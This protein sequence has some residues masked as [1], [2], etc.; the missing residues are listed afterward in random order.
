MPSVAVV[1]GASS[2]IG[3]ATTRA[4]AAAGWNVIATARRPETAESLREIADELSGVELRALDVTSDESVDTC[5]RS[6]LN[7]LG[8]IDLLVNNAGAGHRGTLEQLTMDEL[9]QAMELN[10]FGVARVTKAVLPAM[11]AARTG[12]VIT[13]TSLNGVVALPFSDAYN[14]AKFAVEGLMESLAAVMR[15]FGVY[16]SVLEP[17]PVRTAFFANVGGH[18]DNVS[19]DDPYAELINR[20]NARMAALGSAGQSAESVADVIC[21]IAADPSPALRYQ[22]SEQSRAIAAQKLVDTTGR[23]ILAGTRT[24][25]HPG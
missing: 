25:L 17:G 9:S 12:R 10:F 16:I 24:M 6:I 13:V 22:S 1:T 3:L 5:I 18:V 20:F 8:G 19:D 4:L 21:E 11:R 2:G 15:E 14:A 23:S 7:D